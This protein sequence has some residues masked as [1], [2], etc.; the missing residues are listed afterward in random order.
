MRVLPLLV[1]LAA[2]NAVTLAQV[3]CSAG[4]GPPTSLATQSP[5]FGNSLYGHPNYPNAPGPTYTGFAFVFDL[6]PITAINITRIDLDLYDD[7]NLVQVNSTTTITSPYQVGATSTVEVSVIPGTPWLGNETNQSAWTIYG[8]G[9]LTVAP[10]HTPSQILFNP[11]LTIPAGLWA[12]SL[13]VPPTTNGPNPGPLHPMLDPL[14]TPAVPYVDSVITVQNLQFQREAWA[15]TLASASHRQNIVW[16][17]TPMSGYANWTSFGTGCVSPNL[18]ALTLTTRPV[19]GTTATFQTANLL[20]GTNFNVWLF[21]FTP[22]P[23][24]F[25]LGSFGLPGCNLYL[26]FGSP[27]ISSLTPVTGGVATSQLAIPNDPTYS[28]VVLYAQSAPMTPGFN[29]GFFASNAVCV[30]FGLF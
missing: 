13:R 17:Y 24:G 29:I 16:H 27:I 15:A 19:I 7:G 11:P 8:T 18:P 23:N 1:A 10:F 6:T 28:G 25:S 30:A 9:T 14:T 5:F 12:V 20:A 4:A 21:G 3:N 2:T 26:Q 22:D